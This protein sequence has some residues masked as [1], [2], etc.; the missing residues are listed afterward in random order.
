MTNHRFLVMLFHFYGASARILPWRLPEKDGTFNPYKIMLSELMLQQ[1]QVERVI[2]KYE[3]FIS[4]FPT[5]ESL[6]QSQLS[7]VI[8]LWQGLGY[9][10]R[11]KYLHENAQLL[12]IKPFPRTIEELTKLKGVGSNTAAAILTYSFDEKHIFIET[13][14]RTVL[15]DSF[16]D[17]EKD[18]VSDALLERKLQEILNRYHGSMRDFYW[19]IMDYGSML[20]RQGNTAHRK[21]KSYKK[22]ALF[23]GSIR[24]LRGEIVRRAIKGE[25]MHI[26]KSDIEDSRIDA[27]IEKLVAEKLIVVHN[28][29]LQIF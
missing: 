28:G 25:S 1:T 22:Q 15:I 13:N 2:P 8:S 7:E 9:N 18:Q 16:F 10:R 12:S 5:I 26:L 14:L 29:K 20:K 23:S 6:A 11:A 17:G 19:A 3:A 21:S 24:Q 27:V 4:R